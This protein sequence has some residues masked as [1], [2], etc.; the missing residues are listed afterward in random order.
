[1]KIYEIKMSYTDYEKERK[2]ILLVT[3]DMEF[4]KTS[5]KHYNLINGKLVTGTP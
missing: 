2:T 1:M 5:K 4:A 3:H